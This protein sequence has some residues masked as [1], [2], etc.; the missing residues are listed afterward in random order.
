MILLW[1][2]LPL[3]ACKS[4]SS[5]WLCNKEAKDEGEREERRKGR[6]MATKSLEKVMEDSTST[7]KSLFFCLIFPKIKIFLSSSSFPSQFVRCALRKE[8]N[9][10]SARSE[11]TNQRNKC[12]PITKAINRQQDGKERKGKQRKFFQ[13]RFPSLSLS[14]TSKRHKIE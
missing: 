9:N 2:A 12:W 1:C 6:A 4:N 7:T 5:C 13:L 3:S 11:Y 8:V 10:N 14:L